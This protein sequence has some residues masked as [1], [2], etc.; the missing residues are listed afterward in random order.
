[1]KEYIIENVS[2]NQVDISLSQKAE[3]SE[4]LFD[5]NF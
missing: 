1:M 5:M 4:D 3:P 2:D